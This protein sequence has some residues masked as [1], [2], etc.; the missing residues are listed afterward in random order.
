MRGMSNVG[1][2]DHLPQIPY[3]GTLSDKT[4]H[5]KQR[6][7]PLY[8]CLSATVELRLRSGDGHAALV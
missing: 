7:H 4:L 1:Q 8:D 5:A 6:L 2:T 3:Q